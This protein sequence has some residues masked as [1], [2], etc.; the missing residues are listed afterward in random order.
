MHIPIILE[1]YGRNLPFFEAQNPSRL[2]QVTDETWEWDPENP[3]EPFDTASQ[4]WKNPK[5]NTKGFF[6]GSFFF[7]GCYITLF[8]VGWFERK[9]GG[10][11]SGVGTFTRK[12]TSRSLGECMKIEQNLR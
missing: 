5:K 12:T 11:G 7:A 2:R 4:V 10:W 8:L 1:I 3:D 6:A 9:Y